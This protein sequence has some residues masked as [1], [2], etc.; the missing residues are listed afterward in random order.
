[1]NKLFL[2]VSKI[3]SVYN[4]P[5]LTLR[6][7]D[8]ALDPGL[9]SSMKTGLRDII[10]R[11]KPKRIKRSK[12]A[13]NIGAFIEIDKITKDKVLVLPTSMKKF[14]YSLGLRG[15]GGKQEKFPIPGDSILLT[16]KEKKRKD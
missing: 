13:D 1:M 5:L 3:I 7:I 10:K 16:R 2:E 12:E 6:K 14:G 8:F 11:N 15:V 4:D 9:K